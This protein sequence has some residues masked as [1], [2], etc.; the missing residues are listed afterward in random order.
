M[1]KQE[2]A[3]EQDHAD[4]LA[5]PDAHVPESAAEE[6]VAAVGAD[7][8]EKP[9]ESTDLTLLDH[10]PEDEFNGTGRTVQE[11]IARAD[12]KLDFIDDELALAL[13][14]Y[15]KK[16]GANS[17]K[18]MVLAFV[19][20]GVV[21]GFLPAILGINMWPAFIAAIL[22]AT[23]YATVL[24][25]QVSSAYRRHDYRTTSR[26]LNNA[27]WWN[28]FCTPFTFFTF[29]RCSQIQSRLLLIQG[30]YVEMEAL[31]RI[32]RASTEHRA[33]WEGI[34]KNAFIANDLACTYIAQHRYDEASELLRQLLSTKQNKT[35]HQYATLNLALCLVKKG[36]VAGAV[37]LLQASEKRM[38]KAAPIL[39][40]R[41]ALIKGL[42]ALGE[43]HLDDA[44]LKLEDC[45]VGAHKL[46]ESNEL[47]AF[48]YTSL[49]QVRQKQDRIEEAEL[50]HLTAIDLY[51]ANSDP[52]YWCLAEAI[53]EYAAMLEAIG[54]QAEAGKRLK[55]AGLYESAYLEREMMKIK[56]L[57][58][59]VKHEKPVR[60]LTELVNVDGFPPLSIELNPPGLEDGDAENEE[61]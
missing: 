25:L 32:S 35:L 52:S 40:I 58:Y 60:L 46:D 29:V 57:S 43:G 7:D 27:L 19:F 12:R 11:P 8:A 17:R 28:G 1:D 54:R 50:Y 5:N 61:S 36:D 23:A 3:G 31:L 37:S 47:L 10:W 42:I 21:L 45:M 20:G 53:R 39:R 51:K 44:E 15:G 38:A 14:E 22:I 48:C 9:L 33:V 30:R 26:L 41:V 49:A 6:T 18:F 56:Y 16:Y 13:A 59:R 4:V 34:P 55:E 24:S 2:Q